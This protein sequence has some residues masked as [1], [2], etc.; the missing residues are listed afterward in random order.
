ME[1]MKTEF[2][3]SARFLW[4]LLESGMNTYGKN[5][6]PVRSNRKI[7]VKRKPGGKPVSIGCI[8]ENAGFAIGGNGFAGQPPDSVSMGRRI[9]N[10][11]KET[12]R[13]KMK[14]E[15]LQKFVTGMIHGWK[16]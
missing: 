2:Y 5:P 7:H 16:S 1:T 3:E 12:K 15:Q 14:L 8:L 13:L 6:E 11:E 4:N 9:E 10:L